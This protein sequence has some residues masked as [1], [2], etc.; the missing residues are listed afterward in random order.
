MK[1]LTTTPSRTGLV[2]SEAPHPTVR[3]LHGFLRENVTSPWSI[4]LAWLLLF[5]H[6]TEAPLSVN[7]TIYVRYYSFTGLINKPISHN[8]PNGT[9]KQSACM[10]FVY[11]T[12]CFNAEIEGELTTDKRHIHRNT[13]SFVSSQKGLLRLVKNTIFIVNNIKNDWRTP[14]ES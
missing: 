8:S 1:T 4:T 7:N 14:V 12:P 13:I 10:R 9:F 6:S 3:A 11:E 2:G 5:F